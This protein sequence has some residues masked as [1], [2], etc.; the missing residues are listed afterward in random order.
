MRTPGRAMSCDRMDVLRVAGGHQKRRG[1]IAD[2]PAFALLHDSP[3]FAV[4]EQVLGAAIARS[5]MPAS[6]ISSRKSSPPVCAG[7]LFR[8]RASTMTIADADLDGDAR[9]LLE[10]LRRLLQRRRAGPGTENPHD[11]MA[12]VLLIH[13]DLQDRRLY[14]RPDRDAGPFSPSAAR[15]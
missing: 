1:A 3:H 9:L 8:H 6:A 14:I 10:E 7:R 12:V 13:S 4:V 11:V 5:W 2:G 15:P